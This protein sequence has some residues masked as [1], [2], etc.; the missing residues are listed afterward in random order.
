MIKAAVNLIVFFIVIV[1]IYAT[2]EARGAADQLEE[3]L[4]QQTKARQEEKVKALQ[5]QEQ[6]DSL[7]RD[8]QSSQSQQQL[9]RLKQSKP[10]PSQAQQPQA[11]QTQQ[12]LDQLKND[13]QLQRLQ[14]D[15]QINRIQREADPLRQQQQID[16]L[17]RQQRIDSLQDQIRRNQTQQ[18]LIV[19]ASSRIRDKLTKTSD[20]G[21]RQPF[22]LGDGWRFSFTNLSGRSP[23]S[24]VR[25]SLPQSHADNFS[26][27]QPMMTDCELP[28]PMWP[29]G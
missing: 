11:G 7:K 8:Q 26:F 21:F 29:P 13:Q 10:E 6:I 27:S 20:H 22:P 9:D 18:D 3:V 14:T 12:Q 25:F 17:Q 19:C 4:K 16:N 23:W 24:L 15:Q 5:R 2:N 1:L 28:P